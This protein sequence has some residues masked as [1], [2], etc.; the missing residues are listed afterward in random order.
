MSRI[1][2][3]KFKA[4][5]PVGG[6]HVR[7]Q[8]LWLRTREVVSLCSHSQMPG[9]ICLSFQTWHLA[10]DSERKRALEMKSLSIFHYLLLLRYTGPPPEHR[11]QSLLLPIHLLKSGYWLLDLPV[12]NWR[13]CHRFRKPHDGIWGIQAINLVC[14]TDSPPGMGAQTTVV[15][16][17]RKVL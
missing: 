16:T 9:S 15:K 12:S 8:G 1:R 3:F 14:W 4:C 13:V 5:L 2:G 7:L 11:Y 6:A 10:R 17:H